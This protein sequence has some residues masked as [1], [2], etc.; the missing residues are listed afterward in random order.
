M[1]EHAK[2]VKEL[3]RKEGTKLIG[4][5]TGL[6][7]SLHPSTVPATVMPRHVSDYKTRDRHL[8]SLPRLTASY[9][10]KCGH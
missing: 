9:K 2:C 4:A 8:V 10:K 6:R 1:H 5:V 7:K 3:V